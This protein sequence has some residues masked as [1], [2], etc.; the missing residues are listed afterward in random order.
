MI[1]CDT[2]DEYLERC[3]GVKNFSYDNFDTTNLPQFIADT[4]ERLS[5]VI[6]A[7]HLIGQC[8]DC[9]QLLGEHV[10][11][12]DVRG[13]LNG[14]SFEF[15]DNYFMIHDEFNNRTRYCTCCGP[16]EY[17][18]DY[19]IKKFRK[20]FGMIDW[21][22]GNCYWAATMIQKRF[23]GEICYDVV[24][25]HFVVKY[26]DGRYYDFGGEYVPDD[27][28]NLIEW[29]KFS[30]YDSEQYERIMRDCIMNL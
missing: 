27:R 29:N 17:D 12:F 28:K 19:Y 22:D 3:K 21:N 24:V 9:L 6:A 18:Y 30:E 2:Y 14:I 11:Q 25:G 16:V 10:R 20:R 15:E 26:P 7:K 13:V 5:E 1:L 4:R 23:G 8:T